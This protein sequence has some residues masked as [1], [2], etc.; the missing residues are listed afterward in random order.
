M[1]AMERN[2]RHYNML[3][4]KTSQSKEQAGN[5]KS[6]QRNA[7]VTAA[8]WMCSL[9]ENKNTNPNLEHFS[10]TNGFVIKTKFSRQSE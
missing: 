4:L 10:G 5:F 8:K 7:L 3:I 6:N 9:L 1:R 2:F